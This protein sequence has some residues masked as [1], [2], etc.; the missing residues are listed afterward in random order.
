M[1]AGHPGRGDEHGYRHVA[2]EDL[3]ASLQRA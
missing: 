3:V 1:N 2:L